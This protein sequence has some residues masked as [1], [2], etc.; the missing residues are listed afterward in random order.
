MNYRTV[1]LM[2][3]TLGLGACASGGS[4]TVSGSDVVD[5]I[6][7]FKSGELRLE[8]DTACSGAWGAARRRAKSLYD[9]AL[10][11]DLVHEVAKVGFRIDQTYFYLGRSAEGLGYNEAAST[12]YSLALANSYKCA[13]FI[14][15][16]DGLEVPRESR[17]ALTRITTAPK[18][19]APKAAESVVTSPSP[20]NT[21]ISISETPQQ[22]QSELPPPSP[23]LAI[24]FGNNETLVKDI[25]AMRKENLAKD[26]FESSVEYAQ[27]KQRY[28]DQFGEGKG[29]RITLDIDNAQ[30]REDKLVYFN[31]D[32]EELRIA[33][34]SIS[35]DLV[36]L[37]N[38]EKN[39]FK[40][41]HHSFV[42]V[43]SAE[44]KLRTYK[45]SNRLGA[46][47]DVVEMAVTRYGLAV[48]SQATKDYGKDFRQTFTTRA[49][50]NE[51]RELLEN[52]KIVLE[53]TFDHRYPSNIGNP[54]L[55]RNEDKHKPTFDR[56][57][58]MTDTR[59]AVP[60]RLLKARL[61]SKAGVEVFS[62]TGQQVDV[63]AITD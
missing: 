60:V 5:V 55:L 29:Y 8:C 13:G 11:T 31:P 53:V 51:A 1:V 17:K 44:S 42:Q 37:D 50:K 43:Y 38:G 16:C 52:G 57:I 23:P 27:R 21:S 22:A 19:A 35:R 59:Y 30:N 18:D 58:D 3:L 56:P 46:S 24:V 6:T 63:E 48:L 14:N 20:A 61:L 33:M 36:I 47:I 41:I 34:P 4:R 7:T 62:A 32:T 10:W 12:Y 54:F 25:E 15:V 39:D 49:G 40:W 26:G 28:F 45:A 9:A 2:L